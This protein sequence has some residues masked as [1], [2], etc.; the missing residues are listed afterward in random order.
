MSGSSRLLAFFALRIKSSDP[1]DR[2]TSR[3]SCGEFPTDR[4]MGLG[5]ER[6]VGLGL[7]ATC[8]LI[9]MN[10]SSV[11]QPPGGF[12]PEEAARRMVVPPGFRVEVY[13]AE[14]LVRQ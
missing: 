14:P 12:A 4:V 2:P 13:A 5:D 11:A 8:F 6:L 9:L 10:G 1:N 7:L 3:I